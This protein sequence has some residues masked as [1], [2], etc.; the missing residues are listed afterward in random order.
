MGIGPFIAGGPDNFWLNVCCTRGA[1]AVGGL[2]SACWENTAEPDTLTMVNTQHDTTIS[3]TSIDSSFCN[4]TSIGP[5]VDLSAQ[6][7]MRDIPKY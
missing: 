2:V 1:A 4:V 5:D 6:I 3:F 7:V